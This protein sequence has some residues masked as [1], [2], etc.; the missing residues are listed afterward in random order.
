MTNVT[1]YRLYLVDSS[2]VDLVTQVDVI[3]QVRLDN[4]W[5]DAGPAGWINPVHIVRIEVRA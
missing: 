5:V 4:T 2:K 3:N 1:H